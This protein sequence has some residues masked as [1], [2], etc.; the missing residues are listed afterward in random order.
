V[1]G[2]IH[3]APVAEDLQSA[4]RSVRTRRRELERLLALVLEHVFVTYARQALAAE[5]LQSFKDFTPRQEPTSFNLDRV[6]DQMTDAGGS[7]L[8]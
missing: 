8:C 6:M 2:A 5:Q 7:G 3:A 4:T 1:G